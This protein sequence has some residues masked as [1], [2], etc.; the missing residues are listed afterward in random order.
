M[1]VDAVTTDS[2]AFVTQPF[3]VVAGCPTNICSEFLQNHL[4]V[5]N[6]TVTCR[7]VPSQVLKHTSVADF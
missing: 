6:I 3:K 5:F 7:Q 1:T 2:V 4:R